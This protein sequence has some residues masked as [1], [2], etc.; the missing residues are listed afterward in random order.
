[1]SQLASS[2]ANEMQ[3]IGDG[4]GGNAFGSCSSVG[5]F[6]ENHTLSSQLIIISCKRDWLAL[7]DEAFPVPMHTPPPPRK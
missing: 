4:G 6:N 3:E 2:N 1:M 5:E 7:S